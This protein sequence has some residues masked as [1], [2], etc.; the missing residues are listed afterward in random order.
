MKKT[1]P[2]AVELAELA[3][4]RKER[5]RFELEGPPWQP[6]QPPQEPPLEIQPPFDR[7]LQRASVN[8]NLL[9]KAFGEV[10]A[11]YKHKL[12]LITA[13]SPSLAADVTAECDKIVAASHRYHQLIDEYFA[14]LDELEK[15]I[16]A[17]A[18]MLF[19]AAAAAAQLAEAERFLASQDSLGASTERLVT[20]HNRVAHLPRKIADLEKAAGRLD[21]EIKSSNISH[22]AVVAAIQK[23]IRDEDGRIADPDLWRLK[24][25]LQLGS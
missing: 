3:A 19:Q 11:E 16:I 6:P 18:D 13:S 1:L 10:R 9:D 8:G 4:K 5:E 24:D 21:A 22:E 14:T 17:R 15:K 7:V 20:A 12:A 23:R 2:T 25:H